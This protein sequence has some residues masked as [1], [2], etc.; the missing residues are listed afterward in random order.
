M[1]TLTSLC[2]HLAEQSK[3][4]KQGRQKKSLEDRH[5]AVQMEFVQAQQNGIDTYQRLLTKHN[6]ARELARV[7][8]SVGT[9]TE[10]YW[11]CDLHN[12]MHF[13]NLR[14]DEHAQQEIRD[15]ANIM[16]QCALPFFPISFQAW[17][18]YVRNSYTLSAAERRMLGDI[19]RAHVTTNTAWP[20]NTYGM[21]DREYAE[22]KSFLDL[23]LV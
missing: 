3:T 21:S 5:D 2:T 4:N 19:L 23:T 12:F 11:K 8:T 10:L 15:Y 14:M 6:V 22:F 18:D 1:I 16:Y 20:T 9:Y 7:V 13:L 17:N